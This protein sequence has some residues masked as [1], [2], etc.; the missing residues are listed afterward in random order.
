MSLYQSG[1]NLE[2][3]IEKSLKGVG[4]ISSFE[5]PPRGVGGRSKCLSGP[6]DSPPAADAPNNSFGGYF[7]TMSTVT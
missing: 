5:K 1:A 7:L 3:F 4:G 2:S 6:G